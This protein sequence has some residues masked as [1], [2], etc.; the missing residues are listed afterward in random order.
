[1]DLSMQLYSMDY[2]AHA[3]FYHSYNLSYDVIEILKILKICYNHNRVLAL[4]SQA[5]SLV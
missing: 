5:F 3:N 4:R 2:L 1:M